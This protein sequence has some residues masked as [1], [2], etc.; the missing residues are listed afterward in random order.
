MPCPVPPG[1]PKDRWAFFPPQPTSVWVWVLGLRGTECVCACP[2]TDSCGPLLSNALHSTSNWVGC[3]KLLFAVHTAQTCW[4]CKR[5]KGRGIDKD[6]KLVLPMSNLSHCPNLKSLCNTYHC[7]SLP[8]WNHYISNG[9]NLH[10]HYQ[11]PYWII[12][13]FYYIGFRE[14]VKM[15]FF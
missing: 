11:L 12:W 8:T 3:N 9:C 14:A 15:L 7:E 4:D 1:T 13:I 5:H 10:Y 6:F 2:R